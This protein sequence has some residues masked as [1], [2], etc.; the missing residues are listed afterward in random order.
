MKLPVSCTKKC[1]KHL[2]AGSKCSWLTISMDL[3]TSTSY[4]H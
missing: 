4:H 2:M 3:P 1:W